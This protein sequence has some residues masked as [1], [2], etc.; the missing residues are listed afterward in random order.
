M[1]ADTVAWLPGPAAYDPPDQVGPAAELRLLAAI[2]VDLPGQT[3][4]LAALLV[5]DRRL[6]PKGGRR[7]APVR[8]TPAWRVRLD[9]FDLGRPTT[10]PYSLHPYL[11]AKPRS[12]VDGLKVGDFDEIPKT[13]FP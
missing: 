2:V 12:W 7:L 6:V 11:H 3:Q 8:P 13:K 9:I 4:P 10:G 1:E 5:R